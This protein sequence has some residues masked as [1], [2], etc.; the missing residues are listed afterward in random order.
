V[1]EYNEHIERFCNREHPF[2]KLDISDDVVIGILREMPA[3]QRGQ[4]CANITSGFRMLLEMAV[5]SEHEDWTLEQIKNETAARWWDLTY[6]P[7][8]PPMPFPSSQSSPKNPSTTPP[9]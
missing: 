8:P 1:N 3:K 7:Y 9:G 6:Y 4:I 5:Q 2:E